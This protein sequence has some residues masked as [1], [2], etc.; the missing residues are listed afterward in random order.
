M[1]DQTTF[2][3]MRN[4]LT[5]WSARHCGLILALLGAFGLRIAVALTLHPGF[6][7]EAE[8]VA[9][10]N[11]LLDGQP[12][13]RLVNSVMFIRA[14]GYAMFI[15]AVWSIVPG[16][17]LL[18][19]R[20]TQ[21]VLSTMTCF[22]TYI[23]ALRIRDDRRSA[24]GAVCLAALYPYFLY[25]V[26]T[27]GSECLFAFLI[28][29]GAYL[30]TRGLGRQHVAW[31]YVVGAASVYGLGILVRPN[32]APVE[33]VLGLMLAWRYRH[34]WRTV[35]AL[36]AVMIS[37]T[38]LVTTP[39]NL[40]VRR[41]G[42]GEV[43]VS[44]GGGVNYYVGHSDFAVRIYC[45]HTSGRE[46]TAIVGNSWD[47]DPVFFMVHTMPR[48]EQARLFWRTAFRWDSEH[49]SRQLCLATGKLWNYW[50]PWVEGKG[51]SWKFV[52][53][54]LVSLPLLLLGL[55]GLWRW[56]SEDATLASVTLAHVLGGSLTTMVYMAEVRYR[57]PGI[58]SLLV[59]YAACLGVE[60][61]QQGMARRQARESSSGRAH[62]RER[63]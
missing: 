33:L 62:L 8:Y 5:T 10:A 46:R 39:W 4:A 21:A 51:Y 49:P 27:I 14:P 42:L 56:R 19:I 26:A 17:T 29:L 44:D 63:R 3:A 11:R 53:L 31:G 50:R 61:V 22:I 18:A 59:P 35:A 25:H 43:F 7:D 16:R 48:S 37:T 47:L 38:L 55:A 9:A 54:S 58:D 34:R 24:I 23:V 2:S 41:Q 32:L 20:L 40:A 36:A 52:A 15:A 60:V 45:E 12:L 6:G 28:V 13:P 1:N 30:F 57:I